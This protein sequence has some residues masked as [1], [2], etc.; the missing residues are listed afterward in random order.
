MLCTQLWLI[1]VSIVI[2]VFLQILVFPELFLR[3]YSA[4]LCRVN[5]IA[6]SSLLDAFQILSYFHKH[7]TQRGVDAMLLKLYDP[8]LW[9]SLGVSAVLLQCF[10]VNPLKSSGVRWLHF[11]VFNAIQV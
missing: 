3:R 7:K 8:I 1:I 6:L 5:Y 4:V 10:S 11:K 2:L 9:R